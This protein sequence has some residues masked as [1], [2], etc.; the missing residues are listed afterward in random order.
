MWREKSIAQRLIEVFEKMWEYNIYIF[1]GTHAV[2][3]DIVI[4]NT[5]SNNY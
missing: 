3:V 1:I 5:L 2:A 4:D